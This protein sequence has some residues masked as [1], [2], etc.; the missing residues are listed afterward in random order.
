MN[1]TFYPLNKKIPKA[2][3]KVV[4]CFEN[5]EDKISSTLHKYKSDEVLQI[6]CP[7]FE[8][9]NY[10]VE[11]GKSGEQKIRV[12]VM[13][14]ENGKPELSFEVDAYNREEKI[15]IEVEAGRAW[16]NYQFLKDFYEACCMD[17]VRYLCIAVRKI[18]RNNQDYKKI[19]NFF[20]NMYISNRFEIPL[21]GIL[22]I[23]Y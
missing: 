6:I 2:L 14:G 18:Y 5:C 13:Y 22:I 12:P 19:C 8:R 16:T 23:G 7:E 9:I 3:E 10:V 15:V 4:K 17:N 21:K 20:E 1:W 11:K